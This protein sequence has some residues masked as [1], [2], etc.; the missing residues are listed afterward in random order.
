MTKS[1]GDS[2]PSLAASAGASIVPDSEDE[3][4][5]VIVPVQGDR[6]PID[7]VPPPLGP[8]IPGAR[9]QRTSRGNV[10]HFF[11]QQGK[12]VGCGWQG[13][14]KCD[15]VTCENYKSQFQSYP[16]CKL[17]EKSYC[18]P[19]SWMQVQTP[20]RA[21]LDSSSSGV[22]SGSLTDEEADADS[23]REAVRIPPVDGIHKDE[24]RPPVLA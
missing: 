12:A 22:S 10:L 3:S 4:L 18:L 14:D 13:I 19:I 17:C 7:E 1:M 11:S 9:R 6:V 23:D 20:P 16:I 2:V 5:Q 24:V 15:A 21:D 8:L